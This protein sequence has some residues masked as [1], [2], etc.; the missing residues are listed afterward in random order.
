MFGS[1]WNKAKDLFSNLGKKHG[2]PGIFNK[3]KHFVNTSMD[4][5]KSKPVKNVMESVSKYLPSAGSFYNDAKKYGAITSNMMSGGLDKKLDRFIKHNK[6]EPSIERVPR[7]EL[8]R[9]S[10]MFGDVFG[11]I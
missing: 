11:N 2:I 1:F 6:T 9:N 4:F 10:N 3:A 8:A 7:Q 5:L